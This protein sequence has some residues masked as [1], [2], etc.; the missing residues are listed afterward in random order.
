M[1]VTTILSKIIRTMS[2]TELHLKPT[3]KHRKG[4][5]SEREAGVNKTTLLNILPPRFIW[6]G[7]A[8]RSE[9]SKAPKHRT[10]RPS[11]RT[12]GETTLPTP[13]TPEPV[14]CEPDAGFLHDAPFLFLSETKTETTPDIWGLLLLL[15]SVFQLKR[16]ES[17]STSFLCAVLYC[18]AS[19]CTDL[20]EKDLCFALFSESF[21]KR[22]HTETHKE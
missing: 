10:V 4:E 16:R 14:F 22:L 2:W 9:S 12:L 1:T 15:L 21:A 20:W 6:S 5:R 7:R 18:D 19:F 17:E 3:E 8:A 11:N 13:R